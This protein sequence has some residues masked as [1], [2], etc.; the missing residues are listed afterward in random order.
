MPAH[1]RQAIWL[2]GLCQCVLWGVL[3]YGFS[4]FLVPMERS[5]A[6]PRTAVAGAFSLGLLAMALVAPTV[7][8]WLDRGH[9]ARSFRL[10]V[11]LAVVGLLVVSAAHGLVALYV[12]WTLLGLA[13]AMLLYE[14]AFALVIRA[15][16]D[17]NQ[18][19]RALAAVTVMGGL[20]STIFLPVVSVVIERAGW[21]PAALW[22]AG[23]VLVVAALMERFVLPD[24]MAS[25]G[26]ASTSKFARPGP[27]PPHFEALVAVFAVGTFASMVLTTLLIPLLLARGTAPAAAALVLGALGVAQLPGRV[28]LL[29][30]GSRDAGRALLIVPIVLQALGMLAVVISSSSWSAAAG[31]AVFGLGAGLQTLA[32]PWLVQVLYGVAESGRWNGELARVQGFARAAGPVMAATMA[33]WGSTSIVLL[34]A[35]GGLALTLPLAARLSRVRRPAD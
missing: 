33:W 16:A 29:Q 19:L 30:S 3:Y 2:L 13:M 22:C 28:W 20:A 34:A 11:V 15:V 9:A 26:V 1:L 4:V 8:Q 6:V 12:A 23:S 18:R 5:L 10:G 35:G 25:S 17:S 32:R 24:L 21:R 7:G 27:W 31:V 14:S